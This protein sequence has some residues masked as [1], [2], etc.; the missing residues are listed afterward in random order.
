M[1]T[2][3]NIIARM[4]L[5][6][7]LVLTSASN[8]SALD[9]SAGNYCFDNSR[10]HFSQVKMIVGSV[11]RPFTQVY[12]MTPVAGRGWWQTTLY[13]GVNDITYLVFVETDMPAGTYNNRLYMVIDSLEEAGG[14]V[15]RS[16]NL[17]SKINIDWSKSPTW[18]FYPINDRAQSNGYWRPDYS[19]DATTSGSL[20]II[21][22]N[23]KDSVTISSKDYY[24]D[25]SLWIDDDSEPLGSPNEPLAIEVKGRGNW[26]WRNSNKKPYKIKFASK[27]SPLGLDRSRHFV[28]LAHYHDFSGYLRNTMGFDMSRLLHMP[29]TPTQVPVEVVLNGDYVGLYFLCEKI[30]VEGGRVE[31]MEQADNET[32]PDNATGGWLLELTDDGNIVID[33]YQNNDPANPRFTIVTQSPEVLSPVQRAYIHD[34][35]HRAD[36]CVYVA[37]KNDRG[38]E[39]LIDMNTLAR[40]YVIHE[41]MENVE[42]FS[43]SLFMYKDLGW[44]E[45]LKFGPVWDFD[46]SFF[47]QSTTSD[48]FIYDYDT[49]YPFLWIKE[50]LKFPRFQQQVRDVWREFC[51]NHVM[52][53]A[54]DSAWQWRE[55]VSNAEQQDRLRWHSY[56]SNHTPDDPQRFID[57]ISKKAAWLNKQ[58]GVTGDVNLDGNITAADITA[59]YDNILNGDH[60]YFFGADINNDGNITAADVTALYG[61]LLSQ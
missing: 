37:D 60:H 23:T 19:Y 24:I 25:G 34:L 53:K 58:W 16:T 26:T 35:L 56:A 7:L 17:I 43:G 31:V 30:R 42:A 20:P 3:H 22:L 57:V 29:Y 6:I 40:F 13:T 44:D 52:S 1:R 47:Q 46:N 55:L 54:I 21:Y 15:L 39:Q 49:H 12:D 59:I 5:A 28:L 14:G 61:I 11:T 36:S 27:Q 18:V 51:T 4:V 9:I 45:K 33:Q 10:Q 2:A 32:L 48:H 8:M 38:W 41:V 50:A